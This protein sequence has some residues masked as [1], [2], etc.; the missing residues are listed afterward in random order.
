M[1]SDYHA[2]IV[3]WT[4]R[5]REREPA[6]ETAQRLRNEHSQ[7]D[8]EQ[9]KSDLKNQ[10]I[11]RNWLFSFVVVSYIV[12]VF[13]LIFQGWGCGGFQLED[14]TVT[15]VV[16]AAFVKILGVFVIVVYYYFPG[17]IRKD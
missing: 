14:E 7:H 8:L 16:L 11:V 2:D 9:K 1:S 6:E 3:R 15:S 12:L 17:R 4:K 13:T 5:I 10:G